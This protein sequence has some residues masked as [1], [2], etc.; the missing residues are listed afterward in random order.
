M[1]EGKINTLTEAIAE[2]EK[3]IADAMKSMPSLEDEDQIATDV[4]DSVAYACTPS[5]AA[6]LRRYFS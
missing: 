6:A 2:T 1:A 3:S 4:A 5:V